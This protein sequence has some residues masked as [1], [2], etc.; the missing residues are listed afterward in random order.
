MPVITVAIPA[1]KPR[2]L[3]QA[4]ASVLAQ[5]FT[6]YELLISDDCPDDG[7][8]AVVDGF[9]DPR[10]R[11]I[12]GP[13]RGLVPNS[14]HLW[15]QATCD[16]LKYVYDDDFLLPFALEGLGRRLEAAPEA[17][18]AFSFRH[19]VDG[20]GRITSSPRSLKG[21]AVAS[22]AP[23]VIPQAII[24]SMRNFVGEPSNLLIRRSRFPDASC[25]SQ[26]CGLPVR[27]MIDVCFY[28]NAGAHGPCVGVPEFHAA[29][30]QHDQQVSAG[31]TAPAFA[32]GFIEWELFVRGS[33][34]SG[35]VPTTG[36]DAAVPWLERAYGTLEA[37]FP[38]VAPLRAGLPDLARRLAAGE[39]QLLD[40]P[41]VALW[42]AAQAS[43]RG[44]VANR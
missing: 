19:L 22:Y 36:A 7:V 23:G 20:E 30:R 11:L 13:R 35:L 5:T 28:L 2:H 41:F 10:I 3:G 21:D 25:L 32:I 42:D 24:G 18:Y 1:Y 15:E 34:Q 29:F 39:T 17:A 4:I 26:Y 8:K 33:V 31:R 38:E 43:V 9:R 37:D 12:E 40:A 27:H 16:L 14:A 44:R 6:D